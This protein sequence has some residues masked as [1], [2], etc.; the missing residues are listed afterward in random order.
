LD[1]PNEAKHQELRVD[2]RISNSV[3]PVC[4]LQM[5]DVLLAKRSCPSYFLTERRRMRAKENSLYS[6]L[7]S[8]ATK[9]QFD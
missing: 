8:S 7:M 4:S 3:N 9:L 6:T 2:K 1:D 5:L